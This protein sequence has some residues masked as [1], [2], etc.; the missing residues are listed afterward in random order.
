MKLASIAS[1]GVGI[2]VIAGLV[3][4]LLRT[5]GDRVKR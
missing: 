4:W 3:V 5:Q 2:I 1:L